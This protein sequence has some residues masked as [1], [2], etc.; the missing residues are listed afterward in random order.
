MMYFYR[1]YCRYD[2][3]RK[4]Q[5]MQKIKD[6]VEKKVLMEGTEMEKLIESEVVDVSHTN[7]ASI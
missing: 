7:K 1:T 5:E 6:Y 3:N 4:T 2:W